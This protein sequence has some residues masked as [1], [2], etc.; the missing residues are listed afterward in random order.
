ME[1][2][3]FQRVTGIGLTESDPKIAIHLVQSLMSEV[4]RQAISITDAAAIMNLS[5][6]QMEHFVRV[7]TVAYTVVNGQKFSSRVFNFLC[8]SELGIIGYTDE[9]NFW[10]MVD[11]E[12][13]I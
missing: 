1:L 8:L 5:T 9:S 6:L 13:I 10:L 2:T 3:L 4:E 11:S 7:L 12:E